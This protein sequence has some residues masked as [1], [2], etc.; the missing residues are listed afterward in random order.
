MP[1]LDGESA[2][3]DSRRFMLVAVTTP[4][5][6]AAYVRDTI[7]AR[8][9]LQRDTVLA[10]AAARGWPEPAIYTDVGAAA[11][12][13]TG[14]ALAQLSRDIAAGRRDG[15]IVL[16]RSRISSI[17]AGVEAFLS[18]CARHGAFVETVTGPPVN[19]G[20]PAGQPA[21]AA[22]AGEPGDPAGP[23][24]AAQ[25]PLRAPG[26]QTQGSG[27]NPAAN[28]QDFGRTRFSLRPGHYPPTRSPLRQPG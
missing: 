9:A 16:D 5:R 11:A 27:G 7:A 18:H 2:H 19:P 10:A 25:P 13:H 22:A 12:R 21:G 15:L 23:Q 26:Q 6:P 20:P 28:R 24:A 14:P 1:I 3:G 4:G 8:A 17:P